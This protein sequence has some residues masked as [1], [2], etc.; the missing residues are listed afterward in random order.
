MRKS[1][2]LAAVTSAMVLGVAPAYAQYN[3]AQN[4]RLNRLE[5][6]LTF[7]QKQVY[8]GNTT[9]EQS[10][11]SATSNTQILAEI[12]SI[13]EE[14]RQVRGAVERAA[15]QA[16]R[17]QDELQRLTDDFEY[18]L[19]ALELSE[20]KRKEAPGQDSAGFS[21]H[22]GEQDENPT[23]V[24]TIPPVAAFG[25]GEKEVAATASASSKTGS[26]AK[27]LP[28]SAA[29]EVNPADAHYNNAFALLNNKQ[30]AEAAE[31]FSAFIRQY[32]TDPLVPNA[33]YWLGET[34]YVRGDYV[35][36]TEQFRKG[37]EAA[38][39]G[40]KAADNLLKLGLSLNNVK[41][42]E[43]ACIILQQL[44]TKFKGAATAATTTRAVEARTRLQCK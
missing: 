27:R 36:A 26:G 25:D 6:D 14:L 18:R 32:A 20:K 12:S 43:E 22:D 39:E 11:A 19:Q 16:R 44:V 40:Q 33:Y 17:A 2:M 34:H 28:A 31:G 9:A 13:Q 38:P 8:R 10:Q 35:R 21:I 37:Y 7:L 41:R 4:D 24:G 23:S 3:A 15:Y 42:T 29:L 30:Y 1:I 5:R